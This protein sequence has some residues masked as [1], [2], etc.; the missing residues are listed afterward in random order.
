MLL[1]LLFSGPTIGWAQGEVGEVKQEGEIEFYLES[2][3]GKEKPAPPLKEKPISPID[4]VINL[5]K[6]G[7]MTTNAPLIIGCALLVVPLLIVCRRRG[8]HA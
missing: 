7:E 2:N 5:P 4:K 8:K 6:T 1:L 3:D